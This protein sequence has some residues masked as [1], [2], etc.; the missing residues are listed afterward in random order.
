MRFMTKNPAI[1]DGIILTSCIIVSSIATYLV[2]GI[3]AT[4][5]S[6]LSVLHAYNL[7]SKPQHYKN[8]ITTFLWSIAILVGIYIG[9]F[10]KL[11]NLFYIF[12]I[13]LSFFYYHLYGIDPVFDLSMKYI[14]IFSTIGTVL[15]SDVINQFTVGMFIGTLCT[16]L[17]CYILIRANYLKLLLNPNKLQDHI[18]KLKKNIILR[19]L[20]YSVGL[21][22]CLLISN[23][24]NIGRFYWALL[25]FV[26]VLHPKSESII[27]LTTQRIIGSLLVVLVLSFLYSTPLMPY[28]GIFAILFLA[29]FLPWSNQKSYLVTSF[30]TTGFVLAVI[31]MSQYWLDPSYN[32]F[33]ERVTET[34][35]GGTIAVACSIILQLVRNK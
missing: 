29:F 5:W 27:K 33:F 6:A 8:Y 22:L 30:C 9:Y 20:I 23:W 1:N 11:D 7:F 34:I 21:I 32:L 28:I 17:V 2:M 16:L 10:L 15:T 25:T 4:V 19:S 18:F 24:L 14:I 12:L 31:E 35:L 13:I 26:F 3:E